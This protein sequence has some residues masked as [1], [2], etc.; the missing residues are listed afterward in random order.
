MLLYLLKM[1][2]V[3][4]YISMVYSSNIE[5]LSL[6]KKPLNLYDENTLFQLYSLLPKM[7]KSNYHN[8]PP[9]VEFLT[10]EIKNLL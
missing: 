5:V 2:H 6:L 7:T 1:N 10:T 4:Y 9:L 8:M 3:L